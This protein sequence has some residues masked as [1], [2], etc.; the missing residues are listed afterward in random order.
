M[1]AFGVVPGFELAVDVV[2]ASSSLVSK[3]RER[4]TVSATWRFEGW[5]RIVALAFAT[6]TNLAGNQNH[7]LG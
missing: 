7:G 4:P 2:Q 1:G 5:L 6:A 3:D